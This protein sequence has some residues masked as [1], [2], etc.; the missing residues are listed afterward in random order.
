MKTISYAAIAVA[1]IS[2]IAGLISRLTLTPITLVP[3]GVEAQAILAFANT[4]LLVAITFILLGI[5]K[6]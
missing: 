5:L 1:A 3:G 6:K 4:A 2:L